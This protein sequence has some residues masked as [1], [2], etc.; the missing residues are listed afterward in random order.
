MVKM[1]LE[2][3]VNLNLVNLHVV[4]EPFWDNSDKCSDFQSQ[5]IVS[6]DT[7]E[8][9][10]VCIFLLFRW[11]LWVVFGKKTSH[12]LHRVASIEIPVQNE[13]LVW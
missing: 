5:Q 6:Q 10:N 3:A 11:S 9:A 2:L 13:A 7:D 8:N 12:Y 4:I 1:D